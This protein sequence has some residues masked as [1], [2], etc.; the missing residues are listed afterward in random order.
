MNEK[1]QTTTTADPRPKG[2]TLSRPALAALRTL[3]SH[4]ISQGELPSNV[5]VSLGMSRAWA[6]Q[7][8]AALNKNGANGLRPGPGGGRPCKL[9]ASQQRQVLA[10]L[11]GKR[12]DQCGLRGSLWTQGLVGDLIDTRLGVKI[13]LLTVSTLLSRIGLKPPKP[14]QTAATTH[15]EVAASWRRIALPA[16][17]EHAKSKGAELL[18]GEVMECTS[19]P[20][21]QFWTVN[22]QGAFWFWNCPDLDDDRSWI[23]LANKL[24][25]G[26]NRPVCLV[27]SISQLQ[28]SDTVRQQLQTTHK[29]LTLHTLGDMAVAQP[30]GQWCTRRATNQVVGHAHPAC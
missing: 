13:S 9:S 19:G 25:R 6:Y 21:R 11:D 7:C 17:A 3:A 16:L 10:C 5:A 27:L 30:A 23:T 28:P 22:A 15:P 24:M 26:R 4:R 2:R 20:G 29:R 14:L 12:P 1:P 8:Y 18:F